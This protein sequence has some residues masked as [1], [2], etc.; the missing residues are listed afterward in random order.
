MN[1]MKEKL[2]ELTSKSDEEVTIIEEIL[3]EHFIIGRN[4]KEKI[5]ADFKEKLSLND[6]EADTLYNQCAE[7]I[8]KGIL[9]R[10]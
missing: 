7:I 9:K 8:V 10:K 2:K 3:N 1:N 5:V 4:N 6:E